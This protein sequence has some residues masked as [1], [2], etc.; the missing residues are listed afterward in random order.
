MENTETKNIEQTIILNNR[1]KLSISGTKKIISLKSDL[2][3]L[4]T[5]FG[6]LLISGKNLQLEKLDNETTVSNINGEIDSLK[7][8]QLKNKENLLGKIFKWLT[9]FYQ[10]EK[11][12]I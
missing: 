12:Y 8:L 10:V 4:E 7:F 5:N 9:K 1:E 11:Y 6:G 2:I 3:Q